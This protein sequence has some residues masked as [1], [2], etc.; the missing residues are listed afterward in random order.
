MSEK[1][2]F[3]I[4]IFARSRGKLISDLWELF[5][6]LLGESL[7]HSYFCEFFFFS[8]KFPRKSPGRV[9]THP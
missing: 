1:I 2:R 4:Y 3:L 6:C 9:F 8:D 5:E 7:T